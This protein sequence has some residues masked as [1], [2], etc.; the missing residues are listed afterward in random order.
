MIESEYSLAECE[1]GCT[2]VE[3]TFSRVGEVRL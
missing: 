1:I 2:Y 3:V